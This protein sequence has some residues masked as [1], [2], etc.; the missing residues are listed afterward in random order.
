[1]APPADTAKPAVAADVPATYGRFRL[2]GRIGIGGMAEVFRAVVKGPQGW[3]RELVVK[4]ILP[5]LSG[6]AEFTKMFIREAKISALLVHPNIV[7][8]FEFGEAEGTY[9]I[10]MEG[11]QGVTLRELLT[12]LKKEQRAMPF[13][14][15]ADIAK[16]VCTG[17]DYAHTL[18]GPDGTPLE[19]VH[20][21]V[22]PTNIMLAFNGTVKVLDF[23]IA[24][25]ASFAEEEA[26]KG[27]IK[28]KVAYLAPEQVNLQ[29]FD[30]R[31]DIFALGVVMHEMMT[32][33]R[34]FQAKND[35]NRMRQ[36]LAA[37]IP[38]PSSINAAVPR[39]LDRI[40]MKALEVDPTQRYQSTTEMA[41]DLERTMIAARHSSRDLAKLLR[42][43]FM[44]EADEPL[45]VVEAAA[46]LAPAGPPTGSMASVRSST[47]EI[48]QTDRSRA[49]RA[50][51]N[52]GGI[53]DGA[54]RA[55]Q[56][57]L[58][59]QRRGGQVKAAVVGLVVLAL[60]ALGAKIY[61]PYIA[62][63]IANLLA[64]P[65]PPAPAP[66]PTVVVTPPPAPAPKPAPKKRAGKH[67][68]ADK[69]DDRTIPR[70]GTGDDVIAPS[71]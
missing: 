32:G 36:L 67:G 7:Q 68:K 33:A 30:H 14:V 37:P 22:S 12:K 41:A 16:Q 31:I 48:S 5:Q 34:L 45:V 2:T 44:D 3:E 42:G 65:P 9:F 55:E 40:V 11:V 49:S 71:D 59:H 53:L 56:S 54:L 18:K 24:R 10:A 50:N 15:I 39:E 66:P 61:R 17:L 19:I 60:A 47:Q 38:L 51:I 21:D 1:M 20:Q 46:P 62:P 58:L 23:G 26:K 13:M 25:A 43:L 52:S 6:N 8:T 28:G 35:I 4:R 70:A 29:P 64:A 63:V 27:L 69:T 57:R